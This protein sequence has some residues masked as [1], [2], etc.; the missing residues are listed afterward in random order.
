MALNKYVKNL[1]LPFSP[2]TDTRC[3]IRQAT[4]GY[5]QWHFPEKTG[6]PRI[7]ARRRCR[8]TEPGSFHFHSDSVSVGRKAPQRPGAHAA[9]QWLVPVSG[10]SVS[11]E[12]DEKLRMK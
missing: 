3:C 1:A 9:A 8:T 2:G 4:V 6:E 12:G 11:P 5:I 7:F 10:P